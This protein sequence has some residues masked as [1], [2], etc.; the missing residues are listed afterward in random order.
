MESQIMVSAPSTS[1]L[2]GCQFE[3]LPLDV[4]NSGFGISKCPLVLPLITSTI[5]YALGVYALQLG[6]IFEREEKS[7]ESSFKIEL[8][9]P[10]RSRMRANCA[11]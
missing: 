2:L 5:N 7:S 6:R 11:P 3:L 10:M 9:F 4:A 8:P 1:M